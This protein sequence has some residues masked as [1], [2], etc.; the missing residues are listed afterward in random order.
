MKKLKKDTSVDYEHMED[1]VN[2]APYLPATLGDFIEELEEPTQDIS[3]IVKK[4]E[5]NPEFPE[6]WQTLSVTFST[7]EAYFKFFEKLGSKPPPRPPATMVYE[8]SD[9]PNILDLLK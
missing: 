9:K 5:K 7:E 1:Y 8:K 2:S 4:P 3:S 6:D